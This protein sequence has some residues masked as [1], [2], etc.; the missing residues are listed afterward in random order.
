MRIITSS[1]NT[2]TLPFV[3]VI[4]KARP[5]PTT[6]REKTTTIT[7]VMHQKNSQ[8]S[9]AQHLSTTA[10]ATNQT[11]TLT[12]KLPTGFDRALAAAD[13]DDIYNSEIRMGMGA[14]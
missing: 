5:H 3:L 12:S 6:L 13:F 10:T 7:V 9:Q 1:N 4:R 8:N 11:F 14:V 2:Q